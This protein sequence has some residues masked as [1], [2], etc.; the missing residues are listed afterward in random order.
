MP[1]KINDQ[2]LEQ[3]ST[4]KYHGVIIDETLH[5]SDHI[6]NVKFKANKRLYFVRKLSQF[7]VD[8]TLITLFYKS[9]IDK[10]GSK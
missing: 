5:W 7:E 6:N 9:V 1:L 2:I 8:K 4:Y 10:K 3:V